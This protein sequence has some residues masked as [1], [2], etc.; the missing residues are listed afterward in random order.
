MSREQRKPATPEEIWGILREVSENQRENTEQMKETDRKMQETTEQ[1]KET[2]RKMQETTEQM[3]D[4]DRKMQDTDRKVKK[5]NELF[6]GQ[7]G[8]LMEALVR[9]DL[10]RL[11]NERDIEVNGLAKETTRKFE[12]KEYE[13]D[14]IAINGDAI[15]VV[16]VK[17][18]LELKDVEHFMKKLEIFK[19]VFLEYRDKDIYGAVAYLKQNQGSGGNAE[20]KGL[21]VIEAVGS[22][23]RITN[24]DE[25]KAKKF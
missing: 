16:E 8:K 22:S 5:L 14:I 1:M 10:V 15:V 4:T 7:W 2:D 24:R 12:G 6:T 3:K 9:G 23:A 25:F 19:Q 17:T 18:T 21:Y 20:K 13:F 11:L